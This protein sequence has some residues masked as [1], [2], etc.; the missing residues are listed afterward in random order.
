MTLK[1]LIYKDDVTAVEIIYLI[2]KRL[3]ERVPKETL[4]EEYIS[5][6][7]ATLNKL[8][9]IYEKALTDLTPGFNEDELY[10][11]MGG[12]IC[13]FLDGYLEK[14]LFSR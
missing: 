4:L 14:S 5:G 9:K 6:N 11:Y 1:E 7:S 12:Y 13:G 3:Y 10:N 2:F 8:R